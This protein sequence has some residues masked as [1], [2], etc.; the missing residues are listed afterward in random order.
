M[1]QYFMRPSTKQSGFTLV[2]L[3]IALMV[4]GLLIGG[5]LKGQE[6][7]EN[8]R[9]TAF[10]RQIKAYDTAVMVFRNT[11]SSL[12]GDIKRPTRIPNC[13]ADLCIVPGNGN[14]R[15]VETDVSPTGTETYNFFVHLSK[16]G[17]IQGPDGGT[18]AQ[19]ATVRSSGSTST[20]YDLFVPTL[21]YDTTRFNVV[22]ITFG[23]VNGIRDGNYYYMI[24]L[25][26]RAKDQVDTKIDDGSACKGEMHT[27]GFSTCGSDLNQTYTDLASPSDP[28][29]IMAN[30]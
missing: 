30:F 20:S 18:A 4:I 13:S 17:M 19:M 21:P 5:V 2:E 26:D 27:K 7:I 28:L 23:N 3:A 15:I 16:A 25:T 11:Y 6:L 8:A 22:Y 12:P 9:V 24:G 29:H 10:V 1:Q 14:G